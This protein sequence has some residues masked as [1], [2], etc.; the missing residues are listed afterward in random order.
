MLGKKHTEEAKVKISLGGRAA[1][2]D[3][4]QHE[5]E[6]AALERC[7]VLLGTGLTQTQV[8][9]ILTSEGH[10]NLSGGTI[11]Q[12]WVSKYCGAAKSRSRRKNL[13]K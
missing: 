10:K 8:A 12:R 3:K 13:S 9:T 1:W 6:Q 7:K 11:G 2:R 4:G 5:S